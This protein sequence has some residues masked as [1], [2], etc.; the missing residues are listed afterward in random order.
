MAKFMIIDG[1]SMLSTSYY[2]NLPRTILFEKDEEKRKTHYDEILHTSDGRYTN[3]IFTMLKTMLAMYKKVRPDYIAF[4]FDKSRDTFRRT[5]L[6]A[7]FYK[8]NR[9][10]TPEPLKEQYIAM[11]NILERIGFKVLMDDRYEADDFAASLVERFE[12]PEQEVYVIT[13]DH[14][15]FQLVSKYTR[16]W[17]VVDRKKREELEKK[18]GKGYMGK[19]VY[20]GIPTNVFEYTP[21]IVL[22]EEG[23][24]PE[25]I[26][27]LLAI[28]GDPGDG[29]PGCKGVK[30]AAIPLLNEY[31][32]IEEIYAAIEECENDTKKEKELTTFWKEIGVKVSPLKKLKAGKEEVFLSQKLAQMKR[33]IPIPYTLEDFAFKV[34][35]EEL[36]KVLKEYEMNSIIKDIKAL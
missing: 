26:V 10:A 8:A 23:V 33:D 12:G 2:G 19:E 28:Q 36:E 15:Y 18:Y 20:E 22:G 3:A 35:R 4:V 11:E 32:A 6:G 21:Q 27:P 16:M 7:D 24:L 25:L 5:E 17:R 30:S 1:S 31:G 34:D 13:K 14:D 9:S 29:I